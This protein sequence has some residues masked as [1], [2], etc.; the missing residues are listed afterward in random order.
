[1][2]RDRRGGRGLRIGVREVASVGFRPE[3]LRSLAPAV[4]V[5]LGGLAGC[6]GADGAAVRPGD[7]T[8][9]PAEY[10]EVVR[11]LTA[12]IEAEMEDK[13]L[14][15]VS[16]ALVDGQEVVW[17]D[18][19]GMRDPAG[20]VEASAQTVY[21]VGSVSKLFTDIGVMQL[22]ERGELELDAPILR[23]LPDLP[24]GSPLAEVTLRQLTSHRTGLIRE[25]PVGHYF[26]DTD[27]TLAETVASFAASRQVYPRES[28]I[29]YSN[30][31]IAT[32]GYVLER[33]TG[34]PFASYLESAVLEPMGLT[35]SSFQ[36]R[37][38]LMADLAS[39]TMWTYHGETFPAPGFPLGMA[40]AGSMY[41]TVEDLASFASALFRIHGGATGEV[42]EPATLAAM[43][44]PQFSESSAFSG[45][46]IGFSLS[47]LD[48]RRRVGHGGAIYGFATTL[49]V[50]PD[51]G[52]AVVVVTSLD[53]AN[54]V[55]ERVA[56]FGLRAMVAAGDGEVIPAP[57]PP[58][59]VDADRARALDG[60]YSDGQLGARL[61]ERN[62]GLFYQRDDG[63]TRTRL[64][65]LGD[66]LIVDDR[67]A[68]GERI[69]PTADGIEILGGRLLTRETDPIPESASAEMRQLIGEYGW[70]HNIL[71]I[72]EEGGE[73]TAL[74]EWF[75]EY[76][77]ENLSEDV[78]LFPG[79]GLYA[80]EQ[81]EFVRDAQGEVVGASLEGLVFPRREVGAEEGATFTI[82]PVRPVD[83]LR[84]EAAAA[85]PPPQE[86]EFRAPDLVELVS[87]DPTI[88]L[89]I[90]YATTNNFMSARFY[91]EPRAFLQRPAAEA[92]VQAHRILAE[93]GYGLLIHDGY[94]PWA[95][96]R[97]FWDAT[98]EAQ[99]VF[100]A[101]PANGSRHNR[102]AAIDLTLFD[103]STGEPVE[104]TGGYDEFS[105]RSYP[106]YPGG[107]SQ[108]RWRRELLRDVMESVGFTVYD[109]EWW[110]FDFGAWREYPVLNLAFDE[111]GPG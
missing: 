45:Y 15:A 90:R 88:Q 38:D 57:V 31:G 76:P 78:F 41:S 84:A 17:A 60:R 73:L 82:D 59:A 74:I 22:V 37:P 110:H 16:I 29:K 85:E 54:T 43:W 4:L 102:G 11:E 52:L 12:F 106:D 58:G 9:V 21:R 109:A 19:F 70:D 79:R 96:T 89:D 94:R 5:T 68:F 98:P 86:G 8:D 72:L 95:V 46:G 105:S 32:V 35:R 48:G 77:M 100:V 34:E 53:V 50:L 71:Y 83:E 87:L 67:I 91:D 30:A 18:G 64:R 13:Q 61:T 103:L 36:Q 26:D 81:L 69:V 101:N 108:Q 75:F 6:G 3:V 39:A 56:E 42:V 92:V 7:G 23:Y 33:V 97:M 1:V 55:V 65:A 80:G 20:G 44:T 63:G 107:T 49:Q 2:V 10:Q 27:P 93:A 62:G 66:T 99:K 104:M 51:D 28:R 47:E 111:I 14:P 40:P 25:P 24:A